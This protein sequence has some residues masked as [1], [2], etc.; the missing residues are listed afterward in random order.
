MYY[1]KQ[2]VLIFKHSLSKQALWYYLL[3]VTATFFIVFSGFDWWYFQETRSLTIWYALI[4]SAPLGFALPLIA[5]I[6]LWTF[7]YLRDSKELKKLAILLAQIEFTAW[8]LSTGMKGITNR[9]HPELLGVAATVDLSH[10]F[11]FG[12]LKQN[13]FWGWPSSHTAV[14]FAGATFLRRVY[15]NTLIAN[16]ALVYEWYIGIGVSATIH[17]FSDFVAGALVGYAIGKVKIQKH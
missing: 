17:W 14:A 1:M 9:A 2:Q 16:I 6:V 13:P 15:P 10:F 8:V 5:P 3:A 7:G 12:F 11:H 4:P